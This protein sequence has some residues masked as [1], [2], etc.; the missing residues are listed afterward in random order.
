MP[1]LSG[2]EHEKVK[3]RIMSSKKRGQGPKKEAEVNSYKPSGNTTLSICH[4]LKHVLQVELSSNCN[5]LAKTL[6][7]KA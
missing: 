7:E 1:G 4:L 2:H 5:R 6:T 3:I